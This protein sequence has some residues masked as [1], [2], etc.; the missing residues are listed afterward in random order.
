MK[1][2][3][4]VKYIMNQKLLKV[5]DS[6]FAQQPEWQY[7]KQSKYSPKDVFQRIIHVE[8]ENSSIEDICTDFEG[9]SPD[10]VHKRL[11]ELDFEKTKDEF[12]SIL[13]N[14]LDLFK[15]HG[16][17]NITVLVD[18]TEQL[19]YG[20]ENMV[21]RKG[22]KHQKGTS[23][24]IQYFTASILTATYIIPIFCPFFL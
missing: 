21:L 4:A 5:F 16:N 8:L 2:I 9:C 20:S 17:Q 19:Y 1:N 14:L 10:V 11:K 22:T 3:S 15:I 6:S 24:S 13:L 7:V 18:F 12:N 23:Y